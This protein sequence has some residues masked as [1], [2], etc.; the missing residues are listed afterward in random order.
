MISFRTIGTL[1]VGWIMLMITAE[2]QHIE[3]QI[4][5]TG[6]GGMG[7]NSYLTPV[8][9]EWDRTATAGYFSLLPVG[10]VSISSPGRSMTVTAGGQMFT[11]F[12]DRSPWFGGFS[13]ATLRQRIRD[14]WSVEAGGGLSYYQADYARNMQWANLKLNWLATNFTRLSLRGGTSWRGYQWENGQKSTER[15]DTYGL[16]AEHWFNFNWNISGRFFSSPAHI[17]D[18]S[19]G[20][21]VALGTDYRATDQWRFNVNI[22]MDRF[23]ED[24]QLEGDN[25]AGSNGIISETMSVDDRIYRSTLN[26]RYQLSPNIT[27]KGRLSGLGWSSSLDEDVLT[28][29]DASVGVEFSI[30]PDFSDSPELSEVAW[31][32]A[33]SS[34]PTTIEVHYRGEGR[35]FVTGDFNNWEEPGIPLVELSDNRYQ[36]EIELGAG[37]HEYKIRVQKEGEDEWLELPENSGTVSD[38]FGGRNGKVIVDFDN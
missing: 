12:D 37:A 5:T 14:S 25:G 17:S 35:L 13:N 2:A 11:H 27:F 38:G 6:T 18:P 32:N 7:S 9:S 21:S 33:V 36:A 22:S 16:E 34:S 4:T 26:A 15:Y 30:T 23:T 29:F 19:E 1:F 31:K 20:F 8:F 3:T 10:N 24:F 28:D